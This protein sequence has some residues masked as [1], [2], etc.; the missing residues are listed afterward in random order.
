M[1]SLH[2]RGF[3]QIMVV[4]WS[5]CRK[6]KPVT[7][8]SSHVSYPKLTGRVWLVYIAEFTAVRVGSC[9]VFWRRRD[10]VMLANLSLHDPPAYDKNKPYPP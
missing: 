1:S 7:Q 9:S 10:L 8:A 3:E 2:D 5:E 6:Y 4:V